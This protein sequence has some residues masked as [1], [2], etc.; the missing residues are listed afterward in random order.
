MSQCLPSLLL[1][2]VCC[3][4]GS[5]AD[6]HFPWLS[7]DDDGRALLYFAESP[8]QTDYHMP[9]AVAKAVVTLHHHQDQAKAIELDAVDTEGFVGRKSEPSTVGT[10]VLTTVCNYGNYHGT[11]LS[12]YVKHYAGEPATALQAEAK[13][14]ADGFEIDV[15]P[16]FL[17]G[18]IALHVTRGSEPV[19]GAGITVID[20]SGEQAEKETGADGV[21]TFYSLA[22]GKLGFIVGVTEKTAGEVAGEKYTSKS[23]Y[24][25]LTVDTSAKANAVH[26]PQS[27][28]PLLPEPVASFG[29]AML[30][31]MVYVYS[32]HIGTAH[33]HS[34]DNLSKHFCRMAHR[35]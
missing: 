18:G 7:S 8:L 19:A 4:F 21:A 24:L 5:A 27:A 14:P 32:G 13:E 15:R 2:V 6:A 12:Y 33:A 16:T 25:T 9:E 31:D 34:R 3:L 20:S 11:L 30:D 23:H 29:A 1:A 35:W 10:G 17:D 26:A 28:L 22:A